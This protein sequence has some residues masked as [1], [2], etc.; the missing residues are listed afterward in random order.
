MENTPRYHINNKIVYLKETKESGEIPRPDTFVEVPIGTPDEIGT[1]SE[2]KKK[3]ELQRSNTDPIRV[4]IIDNGVSNKT[5][6]I[7]AS[8]TAGSI[9]A[10]AVIS[11]LVTY[12]SKSCK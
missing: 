1:V 6:V 2:F 4:A 11:S 5:K 12:Y 3:S 9:I 10:A 7:I 8:I